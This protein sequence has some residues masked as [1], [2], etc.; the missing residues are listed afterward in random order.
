MTN[1]W[2]AAFCLPQACVDEIE[3][4]CSDFLWSGNPNITSEDKV[5]WEEYLLRGETF[6]DARDTGQGSLLW[7]K[8]LRLKA[9]EKQLIRMDIRDGCMGFRNCRDIH[10]QEVVED[11]VRFPLSLVATEDDGVSWKRGAGD[12]SDHFVAAETWH[13][14]RERKTEVFWHKLVWLPQGVPRY[15]F[16]TG[17]AVRDRLATGHRTH[18]WGKRSSVFTVENR[19][20]RETTFS[21]H[22]PLHSHSG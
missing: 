9:L 22:V 7:R 17:L 14:L 11:V 18:Q 10:I 20:R 1:F 13:Q 12:Y 2:C 6:W 4:M 5:A 16:I 19:M 15:A 21:L 8:L 3:N